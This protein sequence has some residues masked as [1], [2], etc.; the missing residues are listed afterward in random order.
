[1]LSFSRLER[2]G[3]VEGWMAMLSSYISSRVAVWR[4][5]SFVTLTTSFDCASLPKKCL[6]NERVARRLR[7]TLENG[8]I[9]SGRL[10]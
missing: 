9:D 6:A 1:M 8:K 7:F 10:A 3:D 2:G 4:R 5:Q